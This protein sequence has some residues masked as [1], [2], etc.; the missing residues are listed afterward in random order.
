M[1]KSVI[2]RHRPGF[3]IILTLLQSDDIKTLPVFTMDDFN[4]CRFNSCDAVMSTVIKQCQ[5]SKFNVVEVFRARAESLAWRFM[6]QEQLMVFVECPERSKYIFVVILFVNNSLHLLAIHF[7]QT[8][9]LFEIFLKL[10]RF[11]ANLSKEFGK[12][13]KHFGQNLHFFPYACDSH[14]SMIGH[15]VISLSMSFYH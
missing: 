10:A 3:V 5:W 7:W 6:C 2:T 14:R 1:S 9:F 11:Y 8:L 12:W 15:M 4:N 13:G